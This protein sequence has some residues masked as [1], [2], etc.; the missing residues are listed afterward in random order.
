VAW[1]ISFQRV[2][3]VG[4]GSGIIIDIIFPLYGLENKF[5]CPGIDIFMLETDKFRAFLRLQVV[6][7]AVQVLTISADF[8]GFPFKTRLIWQLVAFEKSFMIALSAF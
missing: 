7:F 1:K 4:Q 2:E 5:Q 3:N 6:F 8:D